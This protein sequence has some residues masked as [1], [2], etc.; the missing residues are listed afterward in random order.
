MTYDEGFIKHA[1]LEYRERATLLGLLP[2]SLIT[3]TRKVRARKRDRIVK[4]KEYY[5]SKETAE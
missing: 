4:V 1:R 2:K 5:K 3:I